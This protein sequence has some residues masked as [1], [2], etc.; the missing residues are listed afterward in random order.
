M[1]NYLL[2]PLTQVMVLINEMKSDNA[3]ILLADGTALGSQ[4]SVSYSD[5]SGQISHMMKN[6]VCLNS[7]TI[8]L[9]E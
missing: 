7:Y 9:F 1:Y 2:L 5:L 4:S 3:T 6:I 8:L